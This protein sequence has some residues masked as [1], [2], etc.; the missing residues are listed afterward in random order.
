MCGSVCH[1]ARGISSGFDRSRVAPAR[2]GCEEVDR[3]SGPGAQASS[4]ETGSA[5]TRHYPSI[6]ANHWQVQAAASAGVVDG[7]HGPESARVPNLSATCCTS[8]GRVA[9]R[10]VF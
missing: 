2:W 8:T 3:T 6:L 9:G 10:L 7:V 1:S 4:L 5:I